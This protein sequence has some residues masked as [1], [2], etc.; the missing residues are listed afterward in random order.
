MP[1]IFIK[2][3][4]VAS[5]ADA[6]GE[7]MDSQGR[8]WNLDVSGVN[9]ATR[10]RTVVVS[11]ELLAG[12]PGRTTEAGTRKFHVSN[13]GFSAQPLPQGEGFVSIHLFEPLVH[14]GRGEDGRPSRGVNPYWRR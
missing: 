8:I 12:K 2:G 4:P 9:P 1:I 3:E 11:G 10:E 6:N 13:E 7:H 5:L 14:K